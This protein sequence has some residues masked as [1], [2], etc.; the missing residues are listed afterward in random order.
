[1]VPP[2]EHE[3]FQGHQRCEQLIVVEIGECQVWHQS[4]TSQFGGNPF[5]VLGRVSRDL[6]PLK[7][8]LVLDKGSPIR[9][10]VC[11]FLQQVMTAMVAASAAVCGRQLVNT[12]EYPEHTAVCAFHD[13]VNHLISVFLFFSWVQMYHSGRLLQESRAFLHP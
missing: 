4:I 13:Y 1:M 5:F 7:L 2:A 11:P 6:V 3:F 9:L 8:L 10:V 12:L